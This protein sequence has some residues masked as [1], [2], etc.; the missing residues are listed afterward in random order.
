MVM[1][2]DLLV[3]GQWRMLTQHNQRERLEDAELVQVDGHR[4]KL[5][6]SSCK[7]KLL[8]L[9]TPWPDLQL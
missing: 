7:P 4:L 9:Q 2:P 6:E 1:V 8:L 5:R 3:K